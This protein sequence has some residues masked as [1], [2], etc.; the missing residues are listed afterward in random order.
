MNIFVNLLNANSNLT[1]LKKRNIKLIQNWYWKVKLNVSYIIN[2]LMLNLAKTKYII[3]KYF[4]KVSF[5]IKK[6]KILNIKQNKF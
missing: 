1:V 3:K 5:N 2:W 6:L 4:N